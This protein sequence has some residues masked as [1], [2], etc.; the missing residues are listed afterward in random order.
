MLSLG[1]SCNLVSI[2]MHELGHLLGFGHE[3]NRP[4]RDQYVDILW[5]N[6]DPGNILVGERS[7][8][9]ADVCTYYSKKM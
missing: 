4:D 6:I 9:I 8:L 3:Q 1:A 5:H 7:A 2:A